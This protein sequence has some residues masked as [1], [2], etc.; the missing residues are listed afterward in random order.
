MPVKILLVN[1]PYQTI[2][3]NFGVG[4]Q[5]P[6][7]LLMVGGALRD[8]GHQVRLLDAECR[9]LSIESIVREV[10]RSD[11]DVV[12]T[13]HAGSTPAHPVCVSM[14][15]AIK[16]RCPRV[17]TVYGGVYPSYHAREILTEP[18]VD[19]IVRGEGEA[20]T[21][22]LMAALAKERLPW[23][24]CPV[25]GV[26]CRIGAR[27]ISAPGRPP[28]GNLDAFRTGWELIEDWDAYRCF[29]LG[30]AAIVQFSRG[31]PHKCT[32]CGQHEFWVR[33]R[34]RD[35]V[36]LAD[37]I[38]RLRRQHGVRFI[39]LA[40]ENP[41]TLRAQWRRFLEELAHRQL[42]VHFFAT[43]RAT[44]IVRDAELLPLYRAAGI[45]YVLMGV[46]STSDEV[47]RQVRKGSTTRHDHQ[48]CQL[49]KRNGIFSVIGHIVGLRDETPATFGTARRQLVHYDG[50][51]LNAMYVTPH[52]W[53]PFA[54]AMADRPVVEPDQRKWD[55]RH[56]VLGQRFMGRL[57]LFARVKS[58][59]L[60]FHLRP[61][62]LLQIVRER[63][64][65]RRRQQ[66]WTLWHAG[67]VW[68]AEVADFAVSR[69]PR[70]RR[71][72][73]R[74]DDL[75]IISPAMPPTRS[76]PVLTNELLTGSHI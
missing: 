61:R 10:R 1:P 62:R 37:E 58:L 11:P 50:D 36:K 53:T 55:Y 40:D 9:H 42:G 66:L 72:P 56:Q 54:K 19:F 59:E 65:F 33:W 29:G 44:D 15:R 74:Q 63:D 18:A 57:G 30:R 32:Y 70:C 17:T 45:L 75:A 23:E 64:P 24:T 39:T 25:A 16:A 71:R 2:T 5:V 60:C 52:A 4:H 69:I 35:P 3:S 7:G 13:G 51:W 47:L 8:R 31:C 49:L 20:T 34:H 12:M 22:E 43:I 68:M 67:M 38:Q 28:I 14:L 41:T 46:E 73:S 48:A 76:L 6:L 26:S 27:I 21:V